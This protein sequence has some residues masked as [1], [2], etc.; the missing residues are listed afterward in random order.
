VSFVEERV[1][2]LFLVRMWLEPAQA[3]PVTWRG[4]VEH[5]PSGLRL[6]FIALRD[7]SDF[8]ALRLKLTPREGETPGQQ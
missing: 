8:I 3:E 7:L 1:E 4:T 2:H 5:L 6:N